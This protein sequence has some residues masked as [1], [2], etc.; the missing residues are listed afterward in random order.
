MVEQGAQGQMVYMQTPTGGLAPVQFGG[1]GGE[2]L[3]NPMQPGLGQALGLGLGGGGQETVGR[4]TPNLVAILRQHP[5][6][7]QMPMSVKERLAV[8]YDEYTVELDQVCVVCSPGFGFRL[9]RVYRVRNNSSQR[10][11]SGHH[12]QRENTA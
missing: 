12:Y 1:R 8:L 3:Y 11:R 7:G 4:K 10:L 6:A 9:C 2:E 5:Q